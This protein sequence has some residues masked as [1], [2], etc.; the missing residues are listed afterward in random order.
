MYRGRYFIRE[1]IYICGDYMDAVVY[2]VFQPAGKRR[3]K[4]KPTSETQAR[5]NQRNAEK[6]L[7]RLVHANFTGKDIAIHIT[8]AVPPKSEEEA[9]KDLYNYIR[10]VKRAREKAGLAPLKYISCTERGGRGGRFHHHIIMNGGM[11]R[12]ELERLWGKGY[13]NTKRLQF[14][15][16]GVSGLARYIVKDKHFF[17]RWNASRNLIQPAPVTRDGVLCRADI[18]EMAAAIEKKEAWRHFEEKYKGFL[19]TDA[20]YT[21]N[22]VNKS[23]YIM[24]DMRRQR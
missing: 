15:E 17:K 23:L 16:S 20:K 22:E 7:T 11:D 6:K 9:Q 21:M 8:Y 3:K 24:F 10:R 5:L 4:C 19:L 2:P 1:T 12:D 18:E 14:G 13:A